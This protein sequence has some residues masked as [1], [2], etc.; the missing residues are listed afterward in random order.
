MK[1][2]ITSKNAIYLIIVLVM[3]NNVEHL[4]YVHQMIARKL[5]GTTELNW[6]HSVASVCVIELAI[7]V[8]VIRGQDVF[9][10]MFTF[11]L[12][13][14]SLI[15][16]PM[17]VYWV[18]GQWGKFFAAMIYS[19]MFT[20][21]IYYFSR[22]AANRQQADA[23]LVQY[24]NNYCE[25][26]RM[27]HE[28]IASLNQANKHLEETSRKLQQAETELQQ[29]TKELHQSNG[30]LLELK[31]MELQVAASCTC[32]KCGRSFLS[33]ASRRSHEGRCNGAAMQNE[34]A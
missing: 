29:K 13:V 21:S 23:E 1:K 20:L 3:L 19:G 24:K 15:Y 11:M 7:M 18:N 4:A 16:Y 30:E 32:K 33:E 8:F 27:R 10:G 28:T 34:A 22:M 6:W 14:L 25:A 12:F 17:D 9:A 26:E 5:F 31:K 2:L